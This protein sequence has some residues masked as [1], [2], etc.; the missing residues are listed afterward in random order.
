[1]K[2][3]KRR[4]REWGIGP[5]PGRELLPVLAVGLVLLLLAAGVMSL[6]ARRDRDFAGTPLRE[7]Q[8]TITD[9][10]YAPDR[11]GV[12]LSYLELDHRS[13]R[14]RR[15]PLREGWLKAGQ[16]VTYSYRVGR[17]GAWLIEELHP[18]NRPQ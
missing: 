6:V 18:L 4:L 16:P 7:N 10:L 12:R 9:V 13:V 8:G 15:E 17:S 5:I 11:D 2:A 14:W 3:R 1:M